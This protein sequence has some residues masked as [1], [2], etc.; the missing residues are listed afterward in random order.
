MYISGS[1]LPLAGAGLNTAVT[2]MEMEPCHAVIYALD[3]KKQYQLVHGHFFKNRDKNGM[4]RFMYQQP[5]PDVAGG[6]FGQ[7]KIMQKSCKNDWNPGTWVLI[8]QFSMIAIQ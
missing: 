4:Q 6:Q 1:R 8:W 7:Y 3:R 5:N 2:T